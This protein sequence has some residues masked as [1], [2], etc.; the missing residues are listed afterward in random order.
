MKKRIVKLKT[1]EEVVEL[2]NGQMGVFIYSYDFSISNRLITSKMISAFG[3]FVEILEPSSLSNYD[4]C[5]VN[6]INNDNFH[7]SELWIDKLW[8]RVPVICNDINDLFENIF[9]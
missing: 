9:N 7:I 5:V 8:S 2:E 4:Y 3:N 1:I 6:K